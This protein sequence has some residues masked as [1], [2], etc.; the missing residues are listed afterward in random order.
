METYFAGIATSC[1][2]GAIIIGHFH[3]L[4]YILLAP[5]L[6]S[7]LASINMMITNR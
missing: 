2:A 3:W 7:T 5:A 4:G 6:L 1:V